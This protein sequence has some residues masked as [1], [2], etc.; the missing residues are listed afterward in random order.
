MK[1]KLS[2][3]CYALNHFIAATIQADYFWTAD[4]I[5]AENDS[6]F[7]LVDGNLKRIGGDP[8]KLMWDAYKLI[9]DFD[10][11]TVE[12]SLELVLPINPRQWVSELDDHARIIGTTSPGT[13]GRETHIEAISK[14]ITF[15]ERAISQYKKADQRTGTAK[16]KRNRRPENTAV[17]KLTEKQL[18]AVNLYGE[19]KGNM[20]QVARRM[21]VSHQTAKQ[22]YDAANKKLGKKATAIPKTQRLRPDH[23]GE[24]L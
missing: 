3:L 12:K 9:H 17:I 10:F 13:H 4:S 24:D 15:V 6:S 8:L 5:D 1:Q 16:R 14:A 20:S 2:E 22:H 18:E 19:C 7:K 21:G 23:L 11:S